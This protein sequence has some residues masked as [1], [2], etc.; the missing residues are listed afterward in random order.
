MVPSRYSELTSLLCQ[1]F[2]IYSIFSGFTP[3]D[4]PVNDSCDSLDF[5]S[6]Q[7]TTKENNPQNLVKNSRSNLA[8]SA[9]VFEELQAEEEMMKRERLL[10][11]HLGK[12]STS[13]LAH[14]DVDT[15]GQAPPKKIFGK[16]SNKTSEKSSTISNHSDELAA[17]DLSKN[18]K[19]TKNDWRRKPPKVLRRLKF[20]SHTLIVSSIHRLL[21][22]SK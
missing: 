12:N 18:D 19:V 5:E 2:F 10:K 15:N 7:A 4:K 22:Y 11:K 21:L 9:K 17:R 3:S 16:S 1:V 8:H 20:E 13:D 14:S 6:D